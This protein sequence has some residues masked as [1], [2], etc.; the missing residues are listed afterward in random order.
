M[1]FSITAF[2]R[3]PPDRQVDLLSEPPYH[4]IVYPSNI[5]SVEYHM[6]A[7]H[8]IGYDVLSVSS[9]P[10]EL[11]F[12]EGYDGNLPSSITE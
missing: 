3:T 9:K 10:V 7:L 12:D 1:L 2:I 4:E 6:N 8:L 5:M 11:A